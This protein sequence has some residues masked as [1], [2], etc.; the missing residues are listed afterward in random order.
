MFIKSTLY[1]LHF[2]L[3]AGTSRGTLHEKDS[4]FLQLNDALKTKYAEASFI[5]GLSTESVG[6]VLQ[7]IKNIDIN[8]TAELLNTVASKK[9]LPALQF[10]LETLTQ[11]NRDND[12][13]KGLKGIPINGLIWMGDIDFMQQQIRQ[14]IKAGF[15]VIKIKIGA[16]GWKQ[17]H[18]L[19]KKIRSK[20]TSEDIEIRVD[21]N[22]AF[23]FGEA[24][25]VLEQL[26]KLRIHSIEQP[27]KKGQIEFMN[28]LCAETPVP[29]ALDEEL[30][31]VNDMLSKRKLIE[32]IKPQYLILKPGLMGGFKS[33]EE[34]I[35][36]AKENNAGF[37]I[38]SALESNIG[39]NAIAQWTY[40]LGLSMPQ[41]LGT[42]GLYSNNIPSPL[43]I[44]G[45]KL[46]YN[47]ENNW[48]FSPIG[49]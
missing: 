42:G 23:S 2:N 12:F 13:S 22:G 21:A 35:Q 40:Q 16:I 10:A 1:K 41:G 39:L 33:C 17:E 27:I 45:N 47:P 8:N 19:L 11:E 14:K 46:F 34:W 28:K 37:W 29:I 26:Y 44:K 31:G 6:D 48:N 4:I 24:Q 15:K 30:I 25:N 32:S 43:E 7:Q 38:T 5:P 18:A 3:P 49:W 36:I 9:M 20:Y